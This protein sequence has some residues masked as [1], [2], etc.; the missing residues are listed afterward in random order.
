[1]LKISNKQSIKGFAYIVLISAGVLL[2]ETFFPQ[3][4]ER[5]VLQDIGPF[6]A[7]QLVTHMFMHANLQ[8][9]F[10]NMFLNAPFAIAHEKRVGTKRFVIDYLL[11]GIGA[12]LFMS[13]MP[14]VFH[15]GML[16][17]SGACAGITALS[18]MHYREDRL[19]EV[20]AISALIIFFMVNAIQGVEDAV[21][22]S[23]IAHMAH[24]GGVLVGALLYTL[25]KKSANEVH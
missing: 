16:G 9:F 11:C 20:L 25:Q 14:T 24:A 3:Y 17:A 23:G 13:L 12:A 6:W 15:A 22:P 1:M 5:F 2:L 19:H 18:L 8:H 4:M 7:M 10:F 21:F